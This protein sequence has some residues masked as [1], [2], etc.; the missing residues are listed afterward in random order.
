MATSQS[1]ST[2]HNLCKPQTA[3]TNLLLMTTLMRSCAQSEMTELLMT[4][5]IVKA[6]GPDGISAWMSRETA[7]HISPSLKKKFNL[8]I[9]SGSFPSLRKK[10]NIVPIPKA[11]DNRNPS[12]YTGPYLYYL[13]WANYWGSMFTQACVHKPTVWQCTVGI[14]KSLTALLATT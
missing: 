1:A 12:N 10:S 14:P 7:A 9:K 13:S 11:N 5:D 8:S 6:S 4:L 2:D 3:L